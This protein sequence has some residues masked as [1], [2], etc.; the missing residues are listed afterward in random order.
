MDG[1]RYCKRF[2]VAQFWKICKD[3]S[4]GDSVSWWIWLVLSVI[5]GIVEL[6][7]FTFVLLWIAVAGFVT[8]LLTGFIPSLGI[9]IGVFVIISIV[10]LIVTRPIAHKW[11]KKTT[12]STRQETLTEK[13]GV[14]IAPAESG[15]Y[16]MVKVDGD[17]WSA[18]SDFPLYEGQ[19]VIVKSSASAVLVVEPYEEGHK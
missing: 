18:E 19:T 5:I 15:K 9:Q 12:Y 16:A 11:R 8:T 1:W 13:R 6:T 14:V 10:L 4:G 17:L 7:T 3:D 2:L